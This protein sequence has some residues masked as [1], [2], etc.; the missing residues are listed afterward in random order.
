MAKKRQGNLKPVTP[1]NFHLLR[2]VR[3]IYQSLA[4][5]FC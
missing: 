4:N 5:G 3:H 2:Y 1:N